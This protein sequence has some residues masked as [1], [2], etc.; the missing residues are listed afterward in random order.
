[1][2]NITDYVLGNLEPRVAA[3]EQIEVPSVGGGGGAIGGTIA[4]T[5]IAYGTAANTIGGDADLTYTAATNTINIDNIQF[6]LTPTPTAP[7]EGLMC[8]NATDGTVNIG[9]PGGN[10][11]LQVGQESIA[12]VKAGE[13]ILNGQVVYVS[14]VTGANLIVSLARADDP[15]TCHPRSIY[16]ATEDIALNQK[17]YVTR[18]GNVRDL[19]TS[20]DS[21]GHALSDNDVLYLSATVAGGFTNVAPEAPNILV[22][23]GGVI[24]ADATAGIISFATYLGGILTDV[25]EGWYLQNAGSAGRLWGGIITDAG[26]GTVNISAGAGVVKNEASDLETE[27]TAIDQGQGSGWT[28][29]EWTAQAGFALVGVGYNIIY[30]D[31]SAGAFAVQLQADFYA[32]FDFTR[33]FTIGRVYYDGVNVTIRICGMNLWNFNRRVQMFGE[34]RFPVERATG[35]MISAT[36]TRNIALTAGVIWAEL[37]NRFSVNAFDSSGA[38]RFTYW[39]RN[40]LGG[41]TSVAT[42]AQI[43]NTYW[44]DNTGTLNDLTAN[45]YG[46]HWVYEVHDSSVHVVYGQGDYTLT[47]SEQASPPTTL[48]GLL[49]AYATLVGKI[50]I[51]KTAAAFTSIQSPFTTQFAAG[52]VS[53]HNDLGGLQGGTTNEYYH[54]TSAQHTG[55]T[56]GTPTRIAQFNAG[57]VLGDSTL[58]KS[59][60]GVLTLSAGG[61][62]TLTVVASGTAALGAGT[63]TA[64]TIN[65]VTGAT[66]THAITSTSDGDTNVSTVLAADANGGLRI[67]RLGVGAAVIAASGTIALPDGGYIGNGAAT[68]RLG[69]DSSGATD[70]ASFVG[71]NVGIGVVPR[72]VFDVVSSSLLHMQMSTTAAD[73]ASK[74]GRI[75]TRH[76]DNT[77]EPVYI[78][79]GA[80]LATS[81][82]V[83][84]G[85]SNPNLNAVTEITFWT[86]ANNT[87]LAGTQRMTINSSGDVL[88][89]T[90]TA[91]G[92]TATKAL[93]FGDNAGNPTPGANTAGV[94]AKDV[95]GTVEM[96][97]VDEA[98]NTAQLTPHN[99]AGPVQPL[100]GVLHWSQ[101]H[102]NEYAGKEKW[103]DME[104]ALL[105]L[106]TLTGEKF[107]YTRRV[108]R[109]SKPSNAPRWLKSL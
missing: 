20:V 55:L 85:G 75:G 66:H 12:R 90:T 95:G 63:L 5:Q 106:E 44:D 28:M 92:G 37:V 83:G 3:L 7:S 72:Y 59:G 89:G 84:I 105:A 102:R 77:E 25:R 27:P 65:D 94:F 76:Y 34:E 80:S 61:A 29:V 57:S 53:N 23:L 24:K 8:W 22:K 6:D 43:D 42:Q 11:A 10:V 87:T 2:T 9:M 15:A 40:G 67:D 48:P 51:Q 82:I 17:G 16:M 46:V 4:A 18:W 107:V 32:N 93:I 70:Y 60:A 36:G 68:A 41:W 109:R 99:Y 19:D 21:E 50:V 52:A 104:R 71:C 56:T 96:F 33:D 73:T 45:R 47:Q 97:A 58:I 79:A 98:G 31:A 100:P 1:M 54:L 91:P 64:A 39:Y 81:S 62:Y 30:W 26:G 78:I 101:Y 108:P 69:F 86:A 49:A 38:G 88:I 14:N 35:M 74:I 103:Y 13:D